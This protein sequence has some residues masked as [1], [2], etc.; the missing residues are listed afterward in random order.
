MMTD[1]DLMKKRSQV[2][3]IVV[4]F[5]PF[6]CSSNI[7]QRFLHSLMLS[8]ILSLIMVI[9]LP[10]TYRTYLYVKITETSVVF[11]WRAFHNVRFTLHPI[12]CA[13][14]FFFFF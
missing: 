14:A 5:V 4:L 3:C 12:E 8:L 7:N 9:A 11:T 13:C 1:V 2:R 10:Q 6:L